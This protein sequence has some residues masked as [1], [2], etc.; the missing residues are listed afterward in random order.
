MLIKVRGPTLCF[1]TDQFMPGK[2]ESS[3]ALHCVLVHFDHNKWSLHFS[4]D[5][6]PWQ[7]LQCIKQELRKSQYLW[8]QC[9]IFLYCKHDCFLF[10]HDKHSWNAGVAITVIFLKLTWY[11]P[12]NDSNAWTTIDM[13]AGLWRA[14][15]DRDPRAAIR[16]TLREKKKRI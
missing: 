16:F 13:K 2:Q 8:A 3:L 14:I 6:K 1:I 10:S 4:P 12:C 11:S 9:G 7:M 5:T 15:A